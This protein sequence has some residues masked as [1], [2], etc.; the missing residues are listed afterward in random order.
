MCLRTCVGRW[1]W[2]ELARKTGGSLTKDQYV[3]VCMQVGST[4]R[5][6]INEQQL[7]SVYLDLKMGAQFAFLTL[8]RYGLV[9]LD[10]NSYQFLGMDVLTGNIEQDFVLMGLEVPETEP[11]SEPEPEPE[12]HPDAAH[13]ATASES[14]SRS[15]V[16]ES[17]AAAP[18]VEEG[19]PPEQ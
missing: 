10:A 17:P 3:T 8:P 4:G 19:E 13:V 2:Q 16:N 7:L 14:P 5:E 9:T 12:L 18:A 6:G 1:R 11:E 15:A